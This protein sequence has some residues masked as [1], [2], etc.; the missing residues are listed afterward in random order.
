MN[1]KLP[2][3]LDEEL[4]RVERIPGDLFPIAGRGG[5]MNKGG[6]SSD[7]TGGE[8]APNTLKS[9]QVARVIDLLSE[10]PI[11]G[12]VGG[13]KGVYFDGVVVRRAD[14]TY[15]FKNANIQFV[16]GIPAQPVMSGFPSSEG[17]VAVGVDLTHGFPIIRNIPNTDTDR[18][19]ITVSVPSLQRADKKTGNI[20]G[21]SVQFRIEIQNNG[22]GYLKIGD[23]TISGKT[24]SNYQRAYTLT[25]PRPGPW[26]VRVTRLTADSDVVELSNSLRWDSFTQIID[27][28][29]NYTNSACVGTII[30][31]EQFRSIPKRT[32]DVEGLLI[33]YPVNMNPDTGTYTGAWNGN[34]AFGY[35]NNPAWVLY[36]LIT[37]GRYGIGDY[38]PAE[39]VDRW[40][41]Y[42]AGVF[43]DQRVKGKLGV[44][45]RRY[46]CNV[47]ISTQQEAFD[48]LAQMASIFRGFTYWSGGQMVLVADQPE[49]P[50]DIY[51]NA[52]VV[53]GVF[54]YSGT[55]RRERHTQ[56]LVAWQDPKQLGETRVIPV[57]DQPGISRY[58]LLQQQEQAY[59]CTSEGQAIRQGKWT[60]YT[61]LYE[62]DS[63][64]YSTGLSGAYL[65]P[66]SIVKVMDANVAGRRRGGRTG[67]GS[68][69]NHIVFDS[70]IDL[71]TGHAYQLNAV[72]AGTGENAATVQ[73]RAFTVSVSGPTLAVDV[74]S[75]FTQPPLPDQPF[76]IT[77]ATLDAA[78]WRVM[79]V[80]QSDLDKYD[81]R[82]VRHY[83][84]KWSYVEQNLSF[85]EPDITDLTPLPPAVTNAKVFE[86]IVQTSSISLQVMATFSWTSLMPLFDVFYHSA[87]D[88]WTHIRTDQHAINVP[89]T[90]GDYVFQVSPISPLGLK[91]PMTEVKATF[92]GLTAPPVTPQNLRVTIVEGVALF[93]WTGSTE[94]D[95]VV[96]GHYELRYS[97]STSAASWNTS[98]TVIASIPGAASTVEANYSVGTWMLRAFDLDGRPSPGW[99]SV[100]ALAADLRYTQYYTIC[101]NPDFSGTHE[102]TDIKVPQDWLVIGVT[103]G[104]WDDQ[105]I[106]M[107]TW[108]DVDLLPL[109]PGATPRQ[110]EG[111]YTFSQ[112][113]D[114]GA[115]FSVRLA[116]DILAFPF[117]QSSDTLD[118][119]AGLTDTWEDWDDAGTGLDG[120]V[121]ILMRSTLDDPIDPGAVWSE[122]APMTAGEHYAR[123][124][125]FQAFLKAPEGQN[126][127]VEKLCITGD[128]RAKIDAGENIPYSVEETRVFFRIKFYL[129]PAVVITVQ[130]AENTD[131]IQVINKT[132]EYFD[133][134][135]TNEVGVPQVGVRS[136]DW[137]AQGY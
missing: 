95:M 136:F 48:L 41:F 129:I 128:F 103:G 9:K 21:T 66:G 110:G 40:S 19:R 115:P 125:E 120:T 93:D 132:R 100:V 75:G 84:Q 46:T 72:I 16:N 52:N 74:T 6:G 126:I 63:V 3:I 45:E 118:D 44:L 81:V 53:D 62:D 20:Y 117:Y 49:D 23:Y 25:L 82:G 68:T 77:E 64:V 87:D 123:S 22:G 89:A 127:G 55:D 65:R 108:P 17:E 30:D 8:E 59:G 28:K 113:L 5:M 122:Y 76:V 96:G 124:W 47:R 134:Q 119:R 73:S 38:I 34:F 135:I 43:C 131:N 29:V 56:V 88:N 54:T 37:N 32:Y 18:L 106:P 1:M 14:N 137:H 36:D 26:D 57:E 42:K 109:L 69:F 70:P 13:S 15:N 85:S 104:F 101:E 33:R 24:T 4:I 35:C 7:T 79:T 116:A 107:S 112:R 80:R 60:L 94:M 39:M 97:P 78:L 10:G 83:P 92:V 71:V 27:D 99:A 12:V 90:A 105:L 86:Y 121:T 111:L 51:T 61:E 114:A 130:N 50:I 67:S 91:G 31:A 2:P 98:Q 58:G 102:G 11:K 133:L